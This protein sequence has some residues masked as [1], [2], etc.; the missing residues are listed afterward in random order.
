MHRFLPTL[1][2]M[3]GHR[4]DEVPV[5]HRPRAGGQSKY[6]LFNRVFAAT[7]DLFGVRWLMAR[8]RVWAVA[9]SGP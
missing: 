4:I 5:G 1:V 8:H 2:R 9:E 3:R 6:G 7:R